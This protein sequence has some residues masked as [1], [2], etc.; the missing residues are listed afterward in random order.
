MIGGQQREQQYIDGEKDVPANLEVSHGEDWNSYCGYAPEIV[1][2][3]AKMLKI[4]V[5]SV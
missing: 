3:L 2:E 5:E 1:V 4:K